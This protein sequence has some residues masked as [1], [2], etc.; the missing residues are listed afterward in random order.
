MRSMSYSVIVRYDVCP[1]FKVGDLKNVG[2]FETA[3]C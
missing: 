2:W 3:V 1:Y